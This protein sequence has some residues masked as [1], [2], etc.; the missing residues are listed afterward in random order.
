MDPRDPLEPRYRS[1]QVLGLIMDEGP[2]TA[3]EVTSVLY[4]HGTHGRG[5][6]KGET[7]PKDPRS[8]RLKLA[9]LADDAWLRRANDNRYRVDPD[10]GRVWVI[11][12]GSERGYVGVYNASLQPVAM[13]SSASDF[14]LRVLPDVGEASRLESQDV[15]NRCLTALADIVASSAE[16]ARQPGALVVG[17]P[18]ALSLD[19]RRVQSDG[20]QGWRHQSPTID[21]VVEMK[22]GSLR[23]R[24]DDLPDLPRRSDGGVALSA[25]ADIVLDTLG[26]MH[27]PTR[28]GVEAPDPRHASVVLG[29]K[30]SVGIRSTVITRGR[31]DLH[32]DREHRR[33]PGRRRDIVYRGA[34][35]DTI[36]LGHSIAL[37]QRASRKTRD[38]ADDGVTWEDVSQYYDL[39]VADGRPCSCGAV[40]PPHL[41]QVA[42]FRAVEERLRTAG[43]QVGPT[44]IWDSVY[45]EIEQETAAGLRGRYIVEETGRLLAYALDNGVRLYDPEAIVVTGKMAFNN[46]LW[47]T[48][49]ET[50]EVG[51]RSTRRSLMRAADIPGDDV[52]RPIGPRGAAWL[53]FDT[54]VF[55][56]LLAK[57][58]GGANH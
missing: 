20:P 22:W 57:L 46:I 1:V 4:P 16:Q 27:D 12:V 41:N 21:E 8:I 36:G 58:D 32:L 30:H 40:D 24:N 15:L 17:M 45:R 9:A 44:D 43:L 50:T 47:S 37:I 25:D 28:L 38:R 53:G 5:D 34:F 56:A 19:N 39:R 18:A 26:A 48:V 6:R 31:S 11:Y 35:G 3:G 52:E 13:A 55:P 23:R 7:V 14:A 10:V 42:S 33:R 51:Q 2:Q 49:M 29:V 54:W